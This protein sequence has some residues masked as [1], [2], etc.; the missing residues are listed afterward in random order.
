MLW[1][2]IT[3][4]VQHLHRKEE[5][6]SNFN[7]SSAPLQRPEQN[8][9]SCKLK[10]IVMST[11]DA[12]RRVSNLPCLLKMIIQL[13]WILFSI[14]HL[15]FN[16]KGHRIKCPRNACSRVYQLMCINIMFRKLVRPDTEL[17]NSIQYSVSA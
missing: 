6:N 13:P 8:E 3:F 15:S 7:G 4:N 17:P 12:V 1:N 9:R 11:H 5:R 14:F 16:Y 2:R 10:H